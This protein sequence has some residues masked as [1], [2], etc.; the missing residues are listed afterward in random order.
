MPPHYIGVANNNRQISGIIV[1]LSQ[2]TRICTESVKIC[3]ICENKALVV[4]MPGK[5]ILYVCFYS[6]F[7]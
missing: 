1:Y 4:F 5:K 7:E 6:F 2:V 3:G